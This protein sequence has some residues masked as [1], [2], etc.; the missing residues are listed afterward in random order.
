MSKAL[1][2]AAGAAA[3]FVVGT[4]SGR[5]TYEK[6]KKQSLTLWQRPAVQEKVGG[7]TQTVKGKVGEATQTAQGKV[8]EA[9][10]TVRDKASQMPHRV[11][12]LA[13]KAT[14]RRSETEE[15]ADTGTAPETPLTAAVPDNPA[16]AE[17]T[18]PPATHDRPASGT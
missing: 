10:H 18:V 16:I 8:G 2:F 3:G 13:K 1:I 12:A 5:Q 4:R 7:A 17:P 15:T 9:T 6:M 14:H 11:T